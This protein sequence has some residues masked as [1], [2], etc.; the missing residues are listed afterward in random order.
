VD[1]CPPGDSGSILLLRRGA[2]SKP[3]PAWHGLLFGSGP[4]VGVNLGYATPIG[5]VFQDIMEVM[6]AN[7]VNPTKET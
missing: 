6:K 4:G 1:F 3:Q 2:P 7:V 5:A